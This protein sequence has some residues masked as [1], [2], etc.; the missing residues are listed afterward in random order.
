[1][2]EGLGLF[3]VLAVYSRLPR[4]A[5]AVSGLFMI[6]YGCFRFGAEFFREP[7]EHLGFI[8]GGWLT[9]GMVLTL[10][11]VVAGIIIMVF[12]YRGSEK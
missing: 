9:M 11:M 3:I 12:A 2:G 10:P 8:S 4:P 1:L 6:G 7:D 5:A